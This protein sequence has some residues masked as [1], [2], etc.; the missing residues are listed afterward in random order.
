MSMDSKELAVLAA[1]ACEDKKAQNIN[2]INI[3]EVS[4]LSDWILI[5]NGLS[6]V[7]VRAI[8]NSVEMRIKEEA[9]RLPIRKEGLNN[10]KWAL[11]DYGD[12]IVN[13][14][15]SNERIFYDL[16]SFWS[17]GKTLEYSARETE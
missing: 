5:T 2:L 4:T 7:Q 9:S 14:F 1:E 16:E 8:I 12:L 15:Q 17:N 3:T 6:D 13:V 11:L 10:A